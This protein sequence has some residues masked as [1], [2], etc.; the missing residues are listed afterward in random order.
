M[1][2][3]Q[4]HLPGTESELTLLYTPINPLRR[5]KVTQRTSLQ[6]RNNSSQ[7]SPGARLSR[8]EIRQQTQQLLSRYPSFEKIL[9]AH[10][11]NGAPY[12]PDH[13]NTS[14]S[15][16]HS[17]E[18]VAILLAPSTCR[19][20][21]DVE[22]IDLIAEKVRER[23]MTS[24][25]LSVYTSLRRQSSLAAN[26]WCHLVWCAK[27]VA[28]K[29]FN[30]KD[31][32]LR[33]HYSLLPKEWSSQ[34]SKP[35]DTRTSCTEKPDPA[36]ATEPIV[37][38]NGFSNIIET[39]LCGYPVTLALLLQTEQHLPS[40]LLDL[41]SAGNSKPYP[42][43]ALIPIYFHYGVMPKNLLACTSIPVETDLS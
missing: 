32:N 30:P 38:E 16:S 15:I 24:S 31:A 11:E 39:I 28:Y 23:F 12:L 37:A 40:T 34:R 26:M 22:K 35:K 17:K 5:C 7:Y 10:W 19:V 27:E 3:L 18:Y 29:L 25:E 36:K 4:P 13:P 9:I 8:E 33:R 20:A 1:P 21:V 14:I 42:Q 41:E 2:L 43:G 6:W